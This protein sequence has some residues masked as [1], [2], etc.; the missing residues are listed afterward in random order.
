MK[1][2][3][4]RIVLYNSENKTLEQVYENLSLRE[5]YGKVVELRRLNDDNYYWI[6]RV[7]NYLGLIK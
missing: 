2:N 1:N 5:D 7:E 6:G 4:N 3:N